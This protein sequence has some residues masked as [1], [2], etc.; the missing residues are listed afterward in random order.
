LS[1]IGIGSERACLKLSLAIALPGD[2]FGI[3][4]IDVDPVVVAG[5]VVEFADSGRGIDIAGFGHAHRRTSGDFH[6]LGERRDGTQDRQRHIRLDL[7][8]KIDTR[9]PGP[10]DLE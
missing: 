8:P 6:L 7:N 2:L 10:G 4:A 1:A 3:E 9:E 5:L